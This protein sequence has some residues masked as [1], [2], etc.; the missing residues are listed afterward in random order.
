M[1]SPEARAAAAER[2]VRDRLARLAASRHPIVIGP[3]TGEVGFELLY[4]IPFLQW[5]VEAYALDPARLVA[6]SRGGVDSWYRH[7][8]P[9]YS[10]V[11]RFVSP[12]AFHEAT[13]FKKQMEVRHFERA[14]LRYVTRD[15]GLRH[16]H[17]LHPSLMYLLYKA[18][19]RVDPTARAFERFARF[20][21]LAL[22]A[23]APAL[24]RDYVAARFYFSSSFPDTPGN[25]TF[26]SSAIA[27]LAG[28]G[29]VVLLNNDI[30][31]DDHRD[32]APGAAG[33]VHVLNAQMS[34]DT[35]LAVQTAVIARAR[36]FVGTYGGYAY[37]APF[38]GVPS[39]GYFSA[40][41]FK[42]HHLDLAQR[43]F[44][45]LGAA[46]VAACDV[47]QGVAPSQLLDGLR[48]AAAS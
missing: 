21:R 15:H 7:V 20:R 31:V 2:R 36:A 37:L 34:A 5:A 44:R 14:V 22:P 9:R 47:A 12:Q 45:A 11:F 35:N 23:E 16:V 43:T 8:T 39:I 41:A 29:P 25:R 18:C 19:W 4:W 13:T 27:D 26:A 32:F 38:C 46:T 6:V 24:P 28:R 10:D 17:L 30:V 42:R 1:A 3:W 48:S 33:G 40:P